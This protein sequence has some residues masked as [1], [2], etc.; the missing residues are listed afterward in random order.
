MLGLPK[1]TE[2]SKQLPKTAIYR[3]FNMSNAEKEKFDA[4]ISRLAI[5]AEISPQT[6]SITVGETV[7]SVF[8]VLVS[9][10]KKDFSDNTIIKVTKLINQNMLL[11][12]ECEGESKLAIYHTKLIQ[13]E[14]KPTDELQ[15]SLNGL[16]LDEIWESIVVQ[17]G[18]IYVEDG[19]TLE[20]QIVVNEQQEK[21]KKEIERLEKLARK[22]TQP[23]KKFELVQKIKGLKEEMLNG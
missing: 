22:E 1:S 17:V 19:N 3:K 13:S 14:W 2:L 9:L 15:L 20:Q 11:V 4:D 21:L 6:L 18:G 10:K 16:N 5:V 7:Q 23:K 8:V 12:L